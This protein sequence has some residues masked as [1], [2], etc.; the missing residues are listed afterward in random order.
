MSRSPATKSGTY[1]AAFR[2]IESTKPEKER[3][4][5]DPFASAFLSRFYQIL[6]AG[7][8]IAF[9]RKIVT[10]CIQFRWPG[11][12]TAAVARTRLIDD[13]IIHAV[14]SQGINQV[15][16]LNATFDTRAHRLNVGVPLHYV[17][18]DHP[19]LQYTKKKILSE[20]VGLPTIHVDYVQLDLNTQQ[21][22]EVF[23]EL[24]YGAHLK[25]LFL[26]EGITTQ[27]EAKQAETIFH[28]VK[29]FSPGTQ[30]IFTYVEKA[31]LENPTAFYGFVRINKLLSRAGE[32]WDFG[33][34]PAELYAFLEL[35]HMKLHYDGGGGDYRAKYFGEKSKQMKGYE[36]LRVVRAEVK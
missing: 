29:N 21:I 6:L 8:T 19:T 26:W 33:I 22:S 3:L 34:R 14:R 17:E 25:T 36:Y 23:P 12:F 27:Q 9:I 2:A 10:A 32:N 30:I 24:F 15:I 13:M 35:H 5:Y 11:S 16:I 4:L 18:M 20:L 28:H 31:V 7:C 1:M